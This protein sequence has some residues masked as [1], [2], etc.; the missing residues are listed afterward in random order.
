MDLVRIIETECIA[1]SFAFHYGNKSHL[2]LIDQDGELEPDKTHLLLFPVRRGQ[3]DR[4]TNSRVYNG[5]FFFVRPDE[6]AQNYYN[7]TEAPESESK[8]ESKI[9]PL[10][11]ALNALELKMQTCYD[12]DILSWESVDAIDVIDA[13]MS[14]LWVTFQIRSY[15]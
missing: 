8:Y 10:I 9:E 1:S 3:Y 2:N 7:E 6:F 13:N 4:N 14:G 11:T 15:E 12:L 5:N